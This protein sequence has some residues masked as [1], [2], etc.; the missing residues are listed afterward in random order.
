MLRSKI[1]RNISEEAL[2]NMLKKAVLLQRGY[3]SRSDRDSEEGLGFSGK[4]LSGKMLK[5]GK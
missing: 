1:K 2:V 5:Q 3:F 4:D